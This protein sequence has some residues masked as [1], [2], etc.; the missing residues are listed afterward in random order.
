MDRIG[1]LYKDKINQALSQTSDEDSLLSQAAKS[2]LAAGG[3]RLR[4]ILALLCCEAISGNYEDAIPAAISYELAH[5][6]SL[7]QDDI[8]DDSKLRHNKPTAYSKYGTVRA[9]MVSDYLIFAIFSELSKYGSS[10]ISRERYGQLLSYFSNAATTAA[11]GEFADVLLATKGGV[12][13]EEYLDMIGFKTAALFGASTATGGIIGGGSKRT[14]ASLYKFGY[15]FGLSFQIMDDILDIVGNP[16]QMGKPVLKDIQNNASNIVVID[17]ISKLPAS[18]KKL[19]SSLRWKSSIP[20]SS[21]QRIITM[22]EETGS[23]EYAI[24]LAARYNAIC[25]ICLRGLP[26]SSAREK[27]D[28]LA[29]ALIAGPI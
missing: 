1:A 8:V 29:R 25:R 21:A 27:L 5:T 4:P 19:I 22:F 17:A 7:V 14:V 10:N 2:A 26:S 23:L 28:R 12:T 6:A 15:N 24:G 9:I 20:E 13:R 3:K 18:G 16:N 11:K